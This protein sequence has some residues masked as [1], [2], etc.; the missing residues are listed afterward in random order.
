MMKRILLAFLLMLPAMSAVNNMASDPMPP[1]FPCPPPPDP[2]K[3]GGVV[4][5]MPLFLR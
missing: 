1:C 3:P 5:E 2:G 4:V